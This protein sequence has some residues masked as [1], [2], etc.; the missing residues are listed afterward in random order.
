M[1]GP[2]ARPNPMLKTI[3]E[4]SAR[5]CERSYYDTT[6]TPAKDTRTIAL[7]TIMRFRRPDFSMTELAPNVARTRI[8]LTITVYKVALSELPVDLNI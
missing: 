7:P 3:I 1:I 6:V 2:A 4:A 5:Y 8:K